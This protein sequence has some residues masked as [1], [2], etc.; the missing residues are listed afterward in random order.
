MKLFDKDGNGSAEVVAA[1]GMISSDITFDKWEPVLPFGIRDVAAIVGR[2]P[3]EAL[4]EFYESGEFDFEKGTALKYLQQAVA[5]FTWLKIIP[6]LDAQ[7]DTAGRSRRLGENEKGLTAL[8]EFKDEENILRLAYEATDAL[9]ESLERF[10]FPFWIN[11]HKCKLRNNC[12]IRTKE[13][14]DEYYN[15]GS[16]RLFVTLLP[17]M[18]E[19]QQAQI[20]PVLGDKVLGLILGGSEKETGVFGDTAARAVVL[21]TMQKAV[22]RLPVE[23]IPEGVVQVQQSQPVKSRLKAEQSARTAVAASLGA[24]AQ[25]CIDRLQQLVADYNAEGM[26]TVPYVGGPIVHSKG[27]SF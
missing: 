3:V 12:L 20:A 2:E 23:V 25:R 13:Q 14:F 8:Q 27:M 4:A 9:V 6:T 22:E 21:L 26:E 5:F 7:H 1:V 10:K 24:D 16:H 19:V 17:I 15:I 18:R 11:S